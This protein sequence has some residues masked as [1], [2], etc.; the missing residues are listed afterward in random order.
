MFKH[1]VSKILIAQIAIAVVVVFFMLSCVIVAFAA[2]IMENEVII[3]FNETTVPTEPIDNIIYEVEATIPYEIEATMCYELETE[4]ELPTSQPQMVEQLKCV[5]I[6]YDAGHCEQLY[7]T[8]QRLLATDAD[9]EAYIANKPKNLQADC[10]V[11]FAEHESDI[12]QVTVWKR[13][14]DGN[15]LYVA[16]KDE[17]GSFL[18]T[19]LFTKDEYQWLDTSAVNTEWQQC[20]T[21]YNPQLV[22]RDFVD[23]SYMTYHEV[24]GRD[25]IDVHIQSYVAVNRTNHGG[26]ENT[27]YDVITEPKQYSCKSEVLARRLKKGNQQLEEDDL[28]KCYRSVLLFFA[29]EHS[30]DVPTDVIWAA[31][32]PQ[33]KQIWMYRNGTYYCR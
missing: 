31:T 8:S 18:V 6:E 4:V 26:F 10:R 32:G 12:T 1:Q 23:V 25:L 3:F 24:S 5:T 22:L 30:I 19:F 9:M 11:W 13:V 15:R 14:V 21:S 16:L 33:G 2:D 27:L 7:D 17:L 29:D 20:A 28:E